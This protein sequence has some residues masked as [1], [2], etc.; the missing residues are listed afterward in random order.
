MRSLLLALALCSSAAAQPTAA[1]SALV[2]RLVD[3]LRLEIGV[4][5]M[6]A[7]AD[8]M[9]LMT[10]QMPG[11]MGGAMSAAF[12]TDLEDAEAAVRA[13]LLEDHRPDLVRDAIAFL[14]GPA[15]DRILAATPFS[16][17]SMGPQ[18]MM[19]LAEDPGDGPMADSVLTVRYARAMMA[20]TQSPE[21]QRATIDIMV[22]SMPPSVAAF[23]DQM[24]GL[25]AIAEAG[26]GDDMLE[27]QLSMMLP[28]LRISLADVPENDVR[29]ATDFYESEAGQYVMFRTTLASIR[30][31]MPA[32]IEAMAPMLS[33]LDDT[34]KQTRPDAPPPAPPSDPGVLEV[35]D[36]MPEIIGG[37]AA[38][39][40]RVV[41]PE[42][43]RD[44]G[45]EGRV[46]VEF[47][48]A[49]D[50]SVRD[51]EVARSPDDRLSEAALEAV[52]GTRFKAG[53]DG[54]KPVAVR[55]TVPITFRLQ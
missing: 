40:S 15:Y 17:A 46:I 54:G 50:G 4:E 9:K 8:S 41:Y 55:F 27:A 31:Q 53:S 36:V 6:N 38:L 24:G 49:P 33:I 43:A 13:S 22:E 18:Q 32:M 28:A 48:V 2:G 34:A 14:D 3:G 7:M 35:A 11:G 5:G 29:A 16:P 19:Q 39:Q 10:S 26:M 20:A 23:F 51:L 44:D 47:V 25:E 1:D 21:L 42:S 52:R 30:L 12:R 45:A 37:M